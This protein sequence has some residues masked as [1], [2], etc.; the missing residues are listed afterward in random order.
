[1]TPD[2]GIGKAEREQRG[3]NKTECQNEQCDTQLGHGGSE[4]GTEGNEGGINEPMRQKKDG[5]DD[6]DGND[7][8]GFQI[9]ISFYS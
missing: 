8:P 6:E 9:R 2:D 3:E 7:W 5:L 1:M 4:A